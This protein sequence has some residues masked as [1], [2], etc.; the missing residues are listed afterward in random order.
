LHINNCSRREGKEDKPA[1][2]QALK[3]RRQS[4]Q[5]ARRIIEELLQTYRYDADEKQENDIHY[6]ESILR[7]LANG[8]EGHL[9][10]ETIIVSTTGQ[11]P[12]QTTGQTKGQLPERQGKKRKAA[13]KKVN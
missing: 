3:F 12:D 13:S 10:G 11:K 4:T 8:E 5:P 9:E 7:A 6:D 2:Q 1:L